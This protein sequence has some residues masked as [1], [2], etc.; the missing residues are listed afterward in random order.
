MSVT[1]S[2]DL[3]SVLPGKALLAG[4]EGWDE[5][6]QPWQRN[7]DQRPMAVVYPESVQDVATAVLFARERGYRV[8]VQ[9]TGHNAAPLSGLEM[10]ILVKTERMRAVVIDATTRTARIDAGVRAAE[11]EEAAGGHGMAALTGTSPDVAVVGY[12]V[13]GGIPVL[14]RRFG[15]A[16]NHVRA[17]DVVT[18]DGRCVRADPGHEPD[19]FWA[20]RGGGGSFGVVTAVELELLPLNN[21][22]AGTLWYPIERAREV[23]QAWQELAQA[24]PPDELTTMGRLM[25]F[26][27]TAE[28]PEAVRGRS[29]V[30]VHVFHA[31]DPVQADRLLAP[32]RALRPVNDTV[33][34]V[35][36]PALADVH[37]D[38]GQ[39]TPAVGDGL[40]LA[41]FPPEAL[42][43]LINAAG[44]DSGS[45]LA[46]VEVRHLEGE[47]A[48]P[49]P[50]NG[51]LASL[52]AKYVVVAGGFA[53]SS[54]LEA[55]V[56]GQVEAVK[57]ALAPWTTAYMHPNFAETPRAPER[58]W[59]EQ[60]YRR[61][62]R[63]KATVDP[64]DLILANHPV[65]PEW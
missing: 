27:P 50:D 2:T 35:R 11:L 9:G 38:P 3:T 40:M 48:R 5:A 49:R 23:L 61:L 20:L 7:V 55:S 51:V 58:F 10:S 22:Y 1:R 21:A 59:A 62:R 42:A 29:F 39:P 53:P 41:D 37:L 31:G 34:T 17:F 65:P 4:Q 25:N 30:L 28:I 32:L 8:A 52:P 26:P 43:A 44:P 64:T 13:G 14:G 33:Q 18:A 16:C 36:V 47:L 19:L 12:T 60:T 45:Q 15:L 6:R 57:T 63:I 56:R 54:D 46:T 24:D